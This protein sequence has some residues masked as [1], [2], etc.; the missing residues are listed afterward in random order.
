MLQ[1]QP[2]VLF[3]EIKRMGT[4]T[5]DL[6]EF[7]KPTAD[8]L[9][10]RYGSLK[11]VLSAGVLALAALSS[12]EREYYMAA[13]GGKIIERNNNSAGPPAGPVASDRN[14]PE[15]THILTICRTMLDYK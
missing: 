15:L 6:T 11:R 8:E 4:R 10:D 7:A 14:I 5:N 12:E 1:G 2:N 9:A 13:A 3:V